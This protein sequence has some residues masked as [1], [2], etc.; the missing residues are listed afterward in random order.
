MKSGDRPKWT[1]HIQCARQSGTIKRCGSSVNLSTAGNDILAEDDSSVSHNSN[2]SAEFVAAVRNDVHFS[3]C[4]LS[5]VFSVMPS[6]HRRHGQDIYDEAVFP[7]LSFHA[8]VSTR[9]NNYKLVNHSFH[10]DLREHF[11]C[12]YCK[13]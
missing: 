3:L 12:T 7:D 4:L 13:Y 2:H 5:T 10:Y 11:F 1:R 8:R 9:G 6:S